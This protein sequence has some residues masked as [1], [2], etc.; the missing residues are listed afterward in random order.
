MS[1]IAVVAYTA[2]NKTKRNFMTKRGV[3]PV[4]GLVV[5]SI[6]FDADYRI[7]DQFHNIGQGKDG[8]VKMLSKLLGPNIDGFEVVS[9]NVER[10]DEDDRYINVSFHV[11]KDMLQNPP[12]NSVMKIYSKAAFENGKQLTFDF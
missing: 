2:N 4:A 12:D 1:K 11:K 3:E 6:Q 7:N 8:L 5:D 9:Y 10:S